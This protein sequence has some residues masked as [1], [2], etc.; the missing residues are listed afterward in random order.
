MPAK[1]KAQLRFIEANP[2]KFGGKAKVQSEWAGPVKGKKLPNK[3][4]KKGK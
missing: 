4:A 3:V 2:G 1:S